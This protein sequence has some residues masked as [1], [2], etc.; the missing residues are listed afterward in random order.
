MILRRVKMVLQR[1]TLMVRE[2]R[3]LHLEIPLKVLPVVEQGL[4]ELRLLITS[5]F[6]AL[7]VVAYLG[8]PNKKSYAIHCS[9]PQNM[10]KKQ[11]EFAK[12]RTQSR[13][14]ISNSQ[15]Q[16]KGDKPAPSND[17]FQ[18]AYAYII[19]NCLLFFERSGGPEMNGL[20]YSNGKL[21]K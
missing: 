5:Q 16:G 7:L 6:L 4:M 18:D 19:R 17:T 3:P 2:T 20:T 8:S 13:N 14:V 21:S 15:C 12:G 10:K 9:P 11:Q 1:R